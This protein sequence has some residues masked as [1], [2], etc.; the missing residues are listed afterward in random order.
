MDKSL[1]LLL[2]LL[3][4][5][6]L[7][8]THTM[9][10]SNVVPSGSSLTIQSG[11][12]INA[13]AGSTVTGFGGGGATPGGA[14]TNIQF[15]DSSAFGGSAGLTWNKATFVET[16]TG[17]SVN[18]ATGYTA[19]NSNTG[20]AAQTIFVANNG[21]ATAQYG[22]TGPSFTAYGALVANQPYLYTSA[23]NGLML[24]ADAGGTIR[25]AAGGNT[26]T[27]QLTAGV[28][29][30]TT[31]FTI[32]GV[33]ASGKIPIG[34]GTKYGPSTPVFPTTVG[35]IGYNV[36]SDGSTGYAAYPQD[37][38]NSSV[39]S[40]SP[41]TS[42]VYLTGSNCTV[43]A[44][45]MK[46]KGQYRCLFDCTKSA[47]TGAIVLTVRVGT[48][49]AI[50]DPAIL[51]FTFGAGTSVADT[52]IFEIIATWR[53]VGSGTSA[54]MQGICRAQHNL[55]T[56]GLFS[57]ADVWTVVATT[58]SGFASNTATN[59]GVSFNGSTAFAGTV[60]LVQSSLL[61]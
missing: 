13:A 16:V 44:G 38:L 45:D 29:N 52:G 32:G 53:T 50:G 30:V 19:F 9:P 22:V 61:Q 33:A 60:T 4:N 27:A 18:G 36:R 12:T 2:L 42:D 48:A 43:A 1:I 5:L 54:V 24:M 21:T 17:T 8:Q 15:N 35:T 39:S 11:G 34:D 37:M 51:T 14:N 26:E 23:G 10:G 58:S 49:G 3:P 31:G 28:L 46:A 47:G 7:A 25:F 40:Q 41:S 59:V 20:G 55:A 57:N 56:T 6:A